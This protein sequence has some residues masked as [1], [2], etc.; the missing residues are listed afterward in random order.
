MKHP[1]SMRR[2]PVFIGIVV[3]VA[4]IPLAATAAVASLGGQA[5][6]T[7]TPSTA[8]GQQSLELA[9]DEQPQDA[10]Q[11]GPA[12]MR[13]DFECTPDPDEPESRGGPPWVCGPGGV[14]AT[15][16]NGHPGGPPWSR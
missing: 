11:T 7:T 9:G 16:D 12:W 4:M 6:T 1:V 10:E 14:A 2:K 13:S 3:A 8:Q 5:G 15:A